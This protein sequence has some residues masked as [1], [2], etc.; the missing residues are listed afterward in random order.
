M[1]Q[2]DTVTVKQS[3]LR[4]QKALI[5]QEDRRRMNLLNALSRDYTTTSDDSES[6]CKYNDDEAVISLS[7][8]L[9]KAASSK[10]RCLR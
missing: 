4:E 9:I 1:P 3:E 8:Q 5:A 6:F 7:V 2:N 10:G